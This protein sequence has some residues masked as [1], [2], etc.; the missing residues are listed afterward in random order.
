VEI[1]LMLQTDLMYLPRT[2]LCFATQT[3]EKLI[4]KPKKYTHLE[5][6]ASTKILE[7]D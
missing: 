7:A 3:V 5:R 4:W 1:E 2:R 6:S